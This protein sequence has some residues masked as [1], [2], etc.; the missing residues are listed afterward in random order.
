MSFICMGIENYCHVRK[1]HITHHTL[2][3][4]PPP[5]WDDG[6]TQGNTQIWS[7]DMTEQQTRTTYFKYHYN[8]N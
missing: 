6:N 8:Q 5:S 4:P 3:T 2:F 1:N 7:K